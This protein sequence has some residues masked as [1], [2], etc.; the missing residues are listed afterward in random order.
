MRIRAVVLLCVTALCHFAAGQ[1]LTLQ[2]AVE[3]GSQNAA[4]AG[5]GNADVQRAEA[6]YREARNAYVP[7][8]VVGSGLAKS[9]GFPMS[10][11]GSAP[12]VFQVNA[13]SF[14]WNPA[15]RQLV[16]AAR[17]D[18]AAANFSAQDQRN[19][20][21]LETTLTYVQLARTMDKLNALTTLVQQAE[22][23]ESILKARLQE[24][25]A[26]QV[27][28]KKGSLTLARTRLRLADA[29]STSDLL[30]MRLAQLTG[31]PLAEVN[32]D[33]ASIPALPEVVDADVTRALQNSPAIKAAEQK[34]EAKLQQAQGEHKQNYPAVDLVG[35][36]GLFTRYNNYDQFFQK[37]E[38]NNATFGVQIRFPFLNF[39]QRAHAQGIDAEALRARKEADAAR[40]QVM[41][42]S[43][44]MKNAVAQ[45][46]AARDVAQ[47][48][49]ELSQADVDAAQA[50]TQTGQA[51]IVDE[52]NARIGVA[53][54]QTAL[55]D[56]SFDF[57]RARIQFLNAT[58]D[59]TQWVGAK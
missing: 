20:A 21:A 2:R 14:L 25:V 35:S 50:R 6:G 19:Q 7:Q 42:D 17:T 53:D 15:Q 59:L 5:M 55:I 27:D 57:E 49:Y 28:V 38:R 16:K 33:P 37:F 52:Q 9:V 39:S 31:L 32:P 30:R 29:Q 12:S 41:N 22:H 1:K 56:A 48:E 3:L 54:K 4:A 34:Y 43:I 11:E 40:Q 36:Y 58:G 47:L 26:S 24:G 45:A 13:Q 23:G 10:I 8:L 44:K 46:A 51:T 18:W